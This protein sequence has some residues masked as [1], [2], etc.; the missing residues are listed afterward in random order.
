MDAGKLRRRGEIMLQLELYER[1][2]PNTAPLHSSAASNHFFQSSLLG[3]IIVFDP[4]IS[5]D[6]CWNFE[7]CYVHVFAGQMAG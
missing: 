4:L 3:I 6:L 5:L 1:Q 2:V 7:G